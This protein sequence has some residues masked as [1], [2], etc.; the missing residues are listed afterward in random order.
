MAL[1]ERRRY[2]LLVDAPVAYCRCSRPVCLDLALGVAIFLL[3]FGG[4]LPIRAVLCDAL[5]SQLDPAGRRLLLGLAQG[6][7]VSGR[8]G[9]DEGG[10]KKELVSKL[11]ALRDDL[12]AQAAYALTLLDAKNG[13]EAVR[14]GAGGVDEIPADGGA[15]LVMLYEH[16]AAYNGTPARRRR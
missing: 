4:G 5:A 7:P 9:R 6:R 11:A 13:L 16:H 14:A 3:H 15:R 10:N 2:R 1:V 12:P 8:R